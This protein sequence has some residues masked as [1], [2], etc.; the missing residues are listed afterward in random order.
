[1]TDN[2]LEKGFTMKRVLTF[3]GLVLLIVI[4]MGTVQ[5]V[6]TSL[7]KSTANN[8]PAYELT[9]EEYIEQ[10]KKNGGD[11][12]EVCSYDYM[13]DKYGTREVL[14]MDMRVASDENDIDPRIYEALGQC[15]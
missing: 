7:Y 15:I 9:K 8:K 12:V 6:K 11:E 4:V 1:M 10:V 2:Q 3:I 14:K 13:I 5:L